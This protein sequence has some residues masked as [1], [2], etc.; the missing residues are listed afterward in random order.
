VPRQ[1]AYDTQDYALTSSD[2]ES[3][4]FVR[5]L[6]RGTP[7]IHFLLVHG[8]LEHSGR[9]LD[10]EEFWMRSYTDVAVTTFDHVGHGRSG[11]ARA[12]LTHFNTY[13]NDLLKVGEFAE[14]KIPA[15][16][17][18]FICA[19]SLGGL[20]TLTRFLDASFGWPFKTDGL[21]FSSPCIKARMILGATS[22]PL[23]ERLDK[24]SPKLH[25]PLI[26]KGSQLTRDVK[27]ANDFDLDPLIPRFITVR[28]MREIVEAT[29][30]IRG[31]SY[32]LNIPSLFMIAGEDVLVVPESTTLFAHGIDKKLVTVVQ[33]PLHHHELWNEIDREDIFKSMKDW[34]GKLLKEKI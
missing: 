17:K 6:S 30:R 3:S 32:Y 5:H 22:E 26:F 28:M 9:H 14:E 1:I 34:V 11:G 23:L 4:L 13:V 8:A 15:N 25:V 12:Y 2:G 33:Y 20:I 24:L 21:L 10:L 7:K 29:Y 19:H 18:R 16:C 31:L 27:R